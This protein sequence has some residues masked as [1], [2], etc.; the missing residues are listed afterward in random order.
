MGTFCTESVKPRSS[1]TL[2][3]HHSFTV[4]LDHL[5]GA[6]KQRRR[7]LEPERL[8]RLEVDYQLVLR[9]SLHRKI[10]RLLALEDAIDVAGSLPVLVD[11]IRAIGNQP[12]VHDEVAVAVDR[13]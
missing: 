4:S 6:G 12:A 10:G 11:R 5:V 8:R 13:R 2:W 9:R 3:I 1:L 7:H